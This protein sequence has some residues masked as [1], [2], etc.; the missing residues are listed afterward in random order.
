MGFFYS[1]FHKPN[2]KNMNDKRAKIIYVLGLFLLP[3]L[4]SYVGSN[5]YILN[6]FID[7]FKPIEVPRESN[8]QII[9]NIY[10]NKKPPSKSS[11]YDDNTNI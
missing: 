10:H 3:S 11:D 8:F 5:Y 6:F 7:T 2:K 9:K 4:V 1:G